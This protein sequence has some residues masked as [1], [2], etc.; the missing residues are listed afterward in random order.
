MSAR[1]GRAGFPLGGRGGKGRLQRPTGGGAGASFPRLF[2]S[3]S[4]PKTTERT[5]L[6]GWA[7]GRERLSLF[8]ESSERLLGGWAVGGT[9]R[10]KRLGGAAGASF[11]G[12]NS[13]GGCVF[14]STRIKRA[15]ERQGGGGCLGGR[16][17]GHRAAG[18][19]RRGSAAVA[20]AALDQPRPA[21]AGAGSGHQLKRR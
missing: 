21:A 8:D 2:P 12:L 20:K 1:M 14:P 16:A 3:H 17:R 13:S 9:W 11:P 6:N 10:S 5:C 7:A 19:P 15:P 4:G 18:G